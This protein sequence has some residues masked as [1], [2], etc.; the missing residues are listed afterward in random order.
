MLENIRRSIQALFRGIDA[1]RLLP[2]QTVF[3]SDLNVFSLSSIA[4]V[5]FVFIIG[6][7]IVAGATAGDPVA[8][9]VITVA[10]TILFFIV[11]FFIRFRLRGETADA[12]TNRTA[13]WLF[14]YWVICI[15][16][17]DLTDVPLVLSRHNVLGYYIF[18][19]YP[20]SLAMLLNIEIPPAW[21]DFL[22]ALLLSLVVWLALLFKTKVQ[23]RDFPV[24]SAFVSGEFP[25][26]VGINTVFLLIVVLTPY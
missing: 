2:S 24:R 10:A 25:I 4:I 3:P 15:I 16:V 6:R 19:S 11:G 26:Y 5:C 21:V 12:K 20:S 8:A 23:E 13:T 17:I 7:G 1:M 22:R 18:S 9:A 14:L